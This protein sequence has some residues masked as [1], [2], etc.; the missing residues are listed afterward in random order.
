M[1]LFADL[2]WAYSVVELPHLG[3]TEM[4]CSA[5][6]FLICLCCAGLQIQC[7]A[8]ALAAYQAE[9]LGRLTWRTHWAESTQC[10]GPEPER[11]RAAMGCMLRGSLTPA[12]G[13]SLREG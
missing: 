9:P 2:V 8:E 6:A 10:T 3:R 5:G 4:N 1:K 12:L 11:C 7:Q 13:P